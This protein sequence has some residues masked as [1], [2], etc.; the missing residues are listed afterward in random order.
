M[1]SVVAYASTPIMTSATLTTG[2]T[3]RTAPSTV[4]TVFNPGANGGLCERISVQPLA[5]TTQTVVRLFRH[6]GSAYDL[7]FEI[8]IGAQTL[9]ATV[10]AEGQNFQAVD[11][12]ELFPIVVPAGSTLKATINDTQTGVKV[13]GQGG[14]F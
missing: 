11:Y 12:P 13:T 9:A 1:S 3:S 10:S 7:L 4:G 14:G 2:D 6:D 8:Q 5:T